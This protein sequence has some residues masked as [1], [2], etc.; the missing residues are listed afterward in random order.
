MNINQNRWRNIADKMYPGLRKK[1]DAALREMG[2][3]HLSGT[4]RKDWSSQKPETGN[5]FIVSSVLMNSGLMPKSTVLCSLET[6]D[7]RIHH[8]LKIKGTKDVLDFSN[9]QKLPGLDYS[10]GV[11][12]NFTSSE[13][14][15]SHP[16]IQKFIYTLRKIQNK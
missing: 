11:E 13:S 2:P 7:G 15:L 16:L 8:Y 6:N 4:F 14:S 10:K 3:D 1:I 5:C 12:E 9:R